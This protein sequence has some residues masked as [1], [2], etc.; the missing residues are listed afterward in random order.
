[1]YGVKTGGF[2]S[3]AEAEAYFDGVADGLRVFAW[4]R[5]GTQYVGTCGTTLAAAQNELEAQRTL[6]V[7]KA[8]AEAEEALAEQNAALESL[9]E[10]GSED[11]GKKDDGKKKP[12]K[13]KK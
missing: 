11:D 3:V 10:G 1:M 13:A 9:G 2:T 4:H 5:D 8:K 6:V 7:G 12:P